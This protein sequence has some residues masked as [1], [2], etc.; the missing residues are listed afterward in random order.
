MFSV[1]SAL[2]GYTEASQVQDVSKVGRRYAVVETMVLSMCA[3]CGHH[4]CYT[5]PLRIRSS[6]ELGV[7]YMHVQIQYAYTGVY[8][9]YN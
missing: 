7:A 4:C 6:S 5:N 9:L 3:Q 1:N 2:H 8:I